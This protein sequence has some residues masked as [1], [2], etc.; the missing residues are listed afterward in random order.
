MAFLNSN[1]AALNLQGTYRGGAVLPSTISEFILPQWL[2]EVT[3][4]LNSSLVMKQYVNMI[5]PIKTSGEE[6]TI[7]SFGRLHVN[8]KLEERPVRLQTSSPSSFKFKADRHIE[9]S[10][11][12]EDITILKSSYDAR[13]LYTEEAGL[14]LARDIDHWI[15]GH[16]VALKAEGQVIRCE[17]GGGDGTTLNLAAIRAAK[18]AMEKDDVPM[19]GVTLVV[20][21]AQYMSLL[22]TEELV[23]AD[24]RATSGG[25]PINTGVVAS[26]Y[27][28]PIVVTN[29]I[30]KNATS[31]FRIGDAD[32]AGA[33]PGVAFWNTD[34]T[35]KADYSLYYPD[36]AKLGNW[37]AEDKVGGQHTLTAPTVSTP[38]STLEVGAYSAILCRKEWL[39]FWMRKMAESETGRET[40][41]LS[42]VMVTHQYYGCKLHRPEFAMVIES[43]EA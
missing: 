36:S 23:N 24:Y 13:K 2:T 40:L 43:F 38:G 1:N 33:T 26:I 30:R 15:L 21:P 8:P 10:R 35:A 41:Y 39:A 5:N 14:A 42:D 11:F 32:T 27:G 37:S 12:F 19:D 31:G 3:R 25:A 9:V 17:T 4:A 16:R 28:I 29:H 34:G 20:S 18:L 7:P 6:I 22:A